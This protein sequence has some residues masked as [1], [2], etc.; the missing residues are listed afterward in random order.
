MMS[1]DER[2]LTPEITAINHRELEGCFEQSVGQY[3]LSKPNRHGY[4]VGLAVIL[5]ISALTRSY[6]FCLLLLG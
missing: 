4:E 5:A 6:C 3:R 1:D 2:E